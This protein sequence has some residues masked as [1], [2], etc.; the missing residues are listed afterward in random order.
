MFQISNFNNQCKK[1]WQQ[2]SE[3]FY[4]LPYYLSM[5]FL[6][7]SFS[8]S[9]QVS[10]GNLSLTNG[11]DEISICALDGTSDAF[12]V[13]LT[14]ETG[15]NSAWVITD[16]NL[17]ILGLPP[18]PPFDLEGAGAGTCLIWHL[19]YNGLI[20]GAEVGMNAAN[21]S[22]DFELSNQI[23]VH[24]LITEGLSGGDLSGGPFAF[25]VG[26]GTADMIPTGSITLSNADGTNTQWV[27]TDANGII[28]GLPPMPS[29]VDF[30]GAGYG[31]CLIWH[32]SFEDG[33]VGAEVGA[34][35]ADL[36]GCF[37]ISNSITVERTPADGCLANGGELFGGPFAFTVGD[38]VADMI[39]EGSI[40]L[41]NASGVNS[42]WVVTDANGIILGLPPMPS[43]VDFDGAG[44]GDC[45]IWH[46]SHDGT[47]AGAAVGVNAAD[48][49]GCFSLSN[50]ITV[51]RTPVDG[52][53]ANGGELF[54]GPFAFTVGDGEADMI[55]E[56]SITLAN[57]SGANTQWLV[58]D[59][60]GNIL[61]LPPMPSAVNFDEA[62]VG[63]CL[64]WHLAFEDGLIGAEVGANAAD[65][66]G[67][68]SLSNSITVARN[69]GDNTGV[70]LNLE[71]SAAS[72]LYEQYGNV[73][74]IFKVT[75]EGTATAT[76]I[77]VDITIPDGLAY[78]S[79]GSTNGSIDLYN[80]VWAIQS[81]EAGQTV[82]LNL[83]LFTLVDNMAITYFTQVI[84][85]DQL[86]S[87]STPDNSSGTISEDDEA[88]ITITPRRAGG[89]GSNQG[90]NDLELQ[91]SANGD[92]YDI[93]ETISFSI[94]VTNNGDE[95]A[96]DVSVEVPFPTGT[97]YVGHNNNNGTY[98]VYNR[99][100]NID[101]I[102][103][104]QTAVLNLDLFTLIENQSIVFISQVLASNEQD[105]DSTPGNLDGLP[106]ED[107]EDSV[108]LVFDNS[109]GK[110]NAD[111]QSRL[112]ITNLMQVNSLYPN[113]A[114]N[115]ISIPVS[116]EIE[117]STTA[118]ILDTNGKLVNQ[119]TIDI[120]RGKNAFNFYI[121]SLSPGTYF[122]SFKGLDKDLTNRK[123]VK[124]N[125]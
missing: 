59:D 78:V 42:Q 36:Q 8:L 104:G 61:G 76:N 110:P 1:H 70:D 60:Q 115:L 117:M 87:D 54:G 65:L 81:I 66:Q 11:L 86:D 79:S 32:L 38:G 91:V 30:D 21:L 51:V 68:F 64:I 69:T 18:S 58:T 17:N 121:D 53:L 103:A 123:F 57:A 101:F 24:R 19:S 90:N 105:P 33:L 4:S 102:G 27:V 41:A 111:I 84:S 112:D 67:C 28:L 106:A 107:D 118:F 48:L 3:I 96:T 22:G 82:Y 25:T 39:P 14:N 73:S 49:E 43:V 56:G 93:Y 34:N 45:L 62:P 94:E 5:L 77:D 26:D 16:D 31:N 113:P 92:S 15:D 75:N 12:D 23:T 122:V 109:F 50:S 119:R 37:S 13:I 52:C 100:W 83:D 35:A 98:E 124:V 2:H 20:T 95:T 44:Y 7:A 108:V 6:A 10:G 85:L 114:S 74:Y 89:F 120:R 99:T 116:S 9:A 80:E 46:L 63:T 29:V 71:L 40:T 88:S 55:P 47:L 97:A 125:R 72:L